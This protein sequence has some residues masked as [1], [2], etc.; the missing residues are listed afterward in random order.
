MS[1]ENIALFSIIIVFILVLL[2][3]LD[4]KLVFEKI[5]GEKK[6]NVWTPI[7][8][9]L[10]AIFVGIG[11]FAPYIFT[12]V[13]TTEKLAANNIGDTMGG[14]MSPFIAIAGVIF[15]FLAFYMQKIANDEIRSQFR[16]QQFEAHFYEMLRLHKENVNEVVYKETSA[17]GEIEIS[18]S[19]K[20][21]EKID[22]ELKK[23]YNEVSSIYSGAY[24]DYDF[25]LNKSYHIL[26]FGL[27][28]EQN[29]LQL[30]FYKIPDEIRK[31]TDKSI[32]D[33]LYRTLLN[34]K[35]Y[36][37]NNFFCSGYSTYFAHLYRHLYLTVKF[38][39]NQSEKFIS[40]EEKRKYLRILRAQL[41]NPEQALMFYNWKSGFGRQWEEMDMNGI[42]KNKFFTDY[43]M[44]HNLYDDIL[45]SDFKLENVKEFKREYRKEKF[46]DYDPLF[47]FE[48]WK[49]K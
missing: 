1:A 23:I 43:R 9:I 17:T 25:Y 32:D 33:K 24:L 40:Y 27:D 19:R 38:V 41:S 26:F 20:A 6:G 5:L 7:F 48:D 39:V 21:F 8:G 46:R 14:T 31:E 3:F 49:I 36:G 13:R 37:V 45:I 44:I 47:E 28:S 18:H 4:L 30:N 42:S 34:H 15:T 11:I 12:N 16:I 35:T 22:L 2:T 10:G 29:G